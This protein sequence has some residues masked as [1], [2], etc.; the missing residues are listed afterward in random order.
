[1]KILIPTKIE[2]RK[3]LIPKADRGVFSTTAIHKGETIETAS[4]LVVPRED[5][6]IL[7]TTILRNYYFMWGKVT[8][9]ICFG[10]GPMY[11][12][13]YNPNASYHKHINKQLVEFT[14][15]KDISKGEEITINYNY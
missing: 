13:S 1:M 4:V 15:L 14:A 3:S 2:I 9:G 12:H 6:S 11:N 7:K 10:Y 5:Y 8:V